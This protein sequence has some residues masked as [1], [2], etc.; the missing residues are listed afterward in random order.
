MLFRSLDKFGKLTIGDGIVS[1]MPALLISIASGIL[2]TRS[3]DDHGFGE[4]VTSELFGFS[5]VIILAS[6]VIFLMSL[7]P[8]YPIIPFLIVSEALTG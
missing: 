6:V 2:V 3:D 5:K 7:V 1:Q 4:S 8:A